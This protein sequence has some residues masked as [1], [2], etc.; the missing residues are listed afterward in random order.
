[1]ANVNA[2]FGF[3]IIQ[4]GMGAPSNF[5]NIQAAILYNGNAIYH[6]D[7]VQMQATGYV[8]QL[9][10][11]VAVSQLWGILLGA[12]YLSSSQGKVIQNNYWPGTDV[13]STG[14]NSV[15]GYLAPCSGYGAPQFIVQ[16]DATGAAF[17]DIGSCSDVVVTQGSTI[18]GIS[19]FALDLT[20]N[21]GTTATYPFRIIGLYGGPQGQGG[22]GGI[23][24]SSTN[25]YGGSA[26]GAYNWVVVRANTAGAGATGI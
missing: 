25:P 6:G 19:A 18:T 1:M 16:S 14:Q 4:S 3:R 22:F 2:P 13:A 20:T 11:G 8:L 21:H 24:P 10:T 17:A 23:Q 9:G 15:I 7:P 5:E 12:Q 26:T